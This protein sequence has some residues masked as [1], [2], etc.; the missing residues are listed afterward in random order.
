MVIAA[1]E[2]KL[3]LKGGDFVVVEVAGVSF[4]L[5]VP[6]ST[7]SALGAIGERVQLHTHL[8]VREESLA[9]YGFA[10]SEERE[11]FET[12]ISVSGVGPKMALALLSALSPERLTHAIASGDPGLLSLVPG[13]GKKTAARLVL[14]L[15]GK[16]EAGKVGIPAKHSEVVAALT[17]L[18]YSVAE[19]SS[20][21][22]L[23]PASEEIPLEEKVRLALQH[24]AKG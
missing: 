23:L 14:E 4:R 10:V 2:G 20:A 22:A 16:V 15:K 6:T 11:L 13:V 7:L 3:K 18:G 1:I 9:L 8:L 5:R 17:G 12:L 21:A 19:A 24:L